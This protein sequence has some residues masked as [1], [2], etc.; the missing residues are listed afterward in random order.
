MIE[1]LALKLANG[2]SNSTDYRPGLARRESLVPS[3]VERVAL[4]CNYKVCIPLVCLN[5]GLQ[6]PA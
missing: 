5:S 2:Y 4:L 6:N 1:Y 3:L